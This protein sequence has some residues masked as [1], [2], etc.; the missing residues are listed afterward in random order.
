M[1]VS[2]QNLNRRSTNKEHDVC[3]RYW[4]HTACLVELT[5]KFKPTCNPPCSEVALPTRTPAI[6][7][8]QS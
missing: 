3:G 5:V 2:Y 6:R 1:C 7:V 8:S 4:M